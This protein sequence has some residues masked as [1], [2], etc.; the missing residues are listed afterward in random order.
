MMYPVYIAPWVQQILLP[1]A[2]CRKECTRPTLYLTFDDGPIPEV[3]PWVLQQLAD[4]EA[5][6]TFFCVG[7]N[8]ERH[9]AIYQA[10][11]EQG[12]TVGNH[13]Q[14]HLDGWKVGT[15]P[16]LNDVAI[17]E[18]WI[19]S[20]LFRPPYG[21]LTPSKSRALRQRGYQLV[22]WEVLSGDFDTSI[23]GE[24]CLQNIIQH[25]RSGSIVVLHDSWLAWSHLQEVL[26]RLLAHYHQL[27]YQFEALPQI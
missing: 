1:Y 13:T 2:Q 21:R 8:V 15:Q 22:Y 16:Y 20:K 12:H 6:A 17:A 5:K 9:P 3:T 4:Y 27:G 7:A 18:Q 10:L 14:H 11:R 25:A 24:Q 19:D 26:P 23:S